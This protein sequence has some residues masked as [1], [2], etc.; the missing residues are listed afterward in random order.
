MIHAGLYYPA[1]SRKALLCREGKAEVERF[2]PGTSIPVERCG[3]LVVAADERELPGLEELARRAEANGVPGLERVGPERMAEI[4]PHV[5]GWPGS[6]RPR[7]R[8]WTSG[9]CAP[10]VRRRGSAPRRGDPAR[11]EV[12]A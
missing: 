11:W 3:K 8:S 1:G 4:E 6:T 12:T 7:P 10:G 9:G 2:A 5:A